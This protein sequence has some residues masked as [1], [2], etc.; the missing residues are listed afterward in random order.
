MSNLDKN[1]YR[2]RTTQPLL[3]L[4]A[5]DLYSHIQDVNFTSYQAN[6]FISILYLNFT[7][8][9]YLFFF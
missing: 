5:T 3:V 7:F 1:R 2:G 9:F 8:F 6:L 4:F